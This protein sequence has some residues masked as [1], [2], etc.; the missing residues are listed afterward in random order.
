MKLQASAALAILPSG[1]GNFTHQYA[2]LHG[3]FD[4]A[5]SATEP[6]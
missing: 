3:H 5:L 6:P 4:A 2:M 1:N